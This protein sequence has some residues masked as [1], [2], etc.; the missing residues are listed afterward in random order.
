MG[1]KE[2]ILSKE[3]LETLMGLKG[4]LNA[5]E[6]EIASYQLKANMLAGG[7]NYYKS[8]LDE[9]A[10][11]MEERYN[12]PN[13]SDWDIDNEGRIISVIKQVIKEEE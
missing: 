6:K 1:N 4:M 8:Q 5:I 2:I 3:D 7:F 10:K 13:D 11:E 12:I 9:K